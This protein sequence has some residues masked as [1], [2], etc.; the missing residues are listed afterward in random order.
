MYLEDWNCKEDVFADFDLS[1][2][3]KEGMRILVASYVSEGYEGS[4][5]LLF[6]KDGKYYEVTGSHCSCNGLDGCWAPEEVDEKYLLHRVENGSFDYNDE[7]DK[8][9]K[10]AVMYSLLDRVIEEEVL[11]Q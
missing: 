7:R 5:Y 2:K 1:E 6:M 9:I 11:L 10:D 8:K 4:A 3:E